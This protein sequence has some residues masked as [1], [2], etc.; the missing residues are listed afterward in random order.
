MLDIPP[1]IVQQQ[2]FIKRA[3]LR[4]LNKIQQSIG[5]L[6]YPFSFYIFPIT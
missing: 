6:F 5:W 1:E 4:I 3:V 2:P